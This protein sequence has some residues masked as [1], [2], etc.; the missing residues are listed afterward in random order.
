MGEDLDNCVE[1]FKCIHQS[2]ESISV[3]FKESLNRINWVTPTS[4]LEQLSMYVT[5]LKDKRIKNSS[6]SAR[7]ITGLQVLEKAATA[8]DGL[9]ADIAEMQPELEKTKIL[10]TAT[11]A[12]LSVKKEAAEADRE[13]VSRDEAEART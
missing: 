13:I 11:M 10:L 3:E 8:I 4:Y 1:I 12:D 5:I 2:V 6:A 9:K 7:L